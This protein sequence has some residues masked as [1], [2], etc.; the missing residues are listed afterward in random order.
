[1]CLGTILVGPAHYMYAASM[2]PS[3]QFLF[4]RIGA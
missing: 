2:V 4:D 3:A 1:V